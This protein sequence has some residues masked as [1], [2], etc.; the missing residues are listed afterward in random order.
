MWEWER[1]KG[2]DPKTLYYKGLW[3]N[4][5]KNDQERILH[6]YYF[7]DVYTCTYVV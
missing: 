6:F 1:Q 4:F 5:I 7:F 3:P 2:H